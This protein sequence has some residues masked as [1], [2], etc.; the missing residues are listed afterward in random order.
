MYNLVRG[1]GGTW[2]IDG[3]K[4]PVLPFDAAKKVFND[5]MFLIHV[6]KKKRPRAPKLDKAYTEKF[7]RGGLFEQ[8]ER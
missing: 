7:K 3:Y 1:S 5:D 2:G 8:L 4:V 6:G